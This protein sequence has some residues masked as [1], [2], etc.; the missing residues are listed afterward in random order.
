[1]LVSYSKQIIGASSVNR[2]RPQSMLSR[3]FAG[4]T[5]LGGAAALQ[6]CMVPPVLMGAALFAPIVGGVV[7]E[8]DAEFEIE[9]GSVVP[10]LRST[11]AA[12]KRLVFIGDDP[13]VA[14]AGEYLERSGH[15]TVSLV[16]ENSRAMTP[17]ERRTA[18][19]QA[20]RSKNADVAF[21]ASSEPAR[22][23]GSTANTVG[24]AALGR[25]LVEMPV[26][27]DLLRCRDG[28]SH[29]MRGTLKSK[30]GMYNFSTTDTK[31][32]ATAG[33]VIAEKML[34]LAGKSSANG[35]AGTYSARPVAATSPEWN[36]GGFTRQE[37]REAQRLL[38]A[39]GHEA[40]TPD[41]VPGPKTAAAIASFQQ[42][43][44]ISATGVLDAQTLDSLRRAAPN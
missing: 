27:I 32:S 7:T 22:T 3:A 23:S 6:G 42:A 29:T 16:T 28:W 11:L 14:Y 5:L 12:S 35:S 34:E 15:F 37:I 33:A 26:T 40:G 44:G 24:N 36:G 18:L 17:S 9:P 43:S 25:V 30:S 1:M 4:A 2:R 41:G 8:H 31:V 19:G 13:A 38:N 20:C 21:V 10:A 39:L